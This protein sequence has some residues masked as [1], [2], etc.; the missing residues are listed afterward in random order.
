MI[1][2]FCNHNSEPKKLEEEKKNKRIKAKL[3]YTPPDI[4]L[5]QVGGGQILY[6]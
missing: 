3:L 1:S 5:P 4:S 6:S 2:E